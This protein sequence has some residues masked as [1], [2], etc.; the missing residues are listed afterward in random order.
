MYVIKY[1]TYKHAHTH[2]KNDWHLNVPKCNCTS[3]KIKP[4]IKAKKIYALKWNKSAQPGLGSFI[5]MC[6][7]ELPVC[8]MS[9]HTIL[10]YLHF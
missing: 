3:N 2:V 1:H 5:I 7:L 9:F 8:L 10:L 4:E 6:L